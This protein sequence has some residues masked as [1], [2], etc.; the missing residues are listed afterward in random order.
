MGFLIKCAI[1]LSVVIFLIPVDDVAGTGRSDTPTIVNTSQAYEAARET[2]SDLGG[3][4][5]RNPSACEI[6]GQIGTT[7]AYKARA[8]AFMSYQFLDRQLGPSQQATLNT[9]PQANANAA[10]LM[11]KAPPPAQDPATTGSVAVIHSNYKP[12][13]HSHVT[14][15]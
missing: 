11:G 7:L 9:D 10:A 8:V 14:P 6:G 2:V 1:F 13:R 4:C 5:A 12:V 15:N 3:F